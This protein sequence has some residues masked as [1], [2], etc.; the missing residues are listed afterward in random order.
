[1]GKNKDKSK[2]NQ[3]KLSPLGKVISFYKTLF[4]PNPKPPLLKSKK[5]YLEIP[6]EVEKLLD[7]G[8]LTNYPTPKQINENLKEYLTRIIDKIIWERTML[9]QQSNL[10]KYQELQ[11]QEKQNKLNEEQIRI[12]QE[13]L[14]NV[15][16]VHE[17]LTFYLNQ[18]VIILLL[19]GICTGLGIAIGINLPE[20]V[21]CHSEHSVCW[22]TR[23]RTK[24]LQK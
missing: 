6:R 22:H 21:Q 14:K 2:P 12:E 13:Y 15:E 19:L 4:K 17:R 16:K 9:N 5:E 7:Y 1:M 8:L 23:L 3:L 11:L 24:T 18:Y 10:A 20:K